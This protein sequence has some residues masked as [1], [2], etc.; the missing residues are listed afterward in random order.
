MSER[1]N[2]VELIGNSRNG[3]IR[4]ADIPDLVKEMTEVQG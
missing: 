4:T 1:E 2:F 3:V